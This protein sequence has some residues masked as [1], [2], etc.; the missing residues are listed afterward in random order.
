MRRVHTR[1]ERIAGSVVAVEAGDASYRELARL[2]WPGGTSLA[3]VVRLE[4]GRAFF[5]PTIHGRRDRR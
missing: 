1:L 5:I 2:D 3:Q 4:G